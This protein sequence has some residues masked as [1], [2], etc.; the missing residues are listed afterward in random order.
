[1]IEG[2]GFSIYDGLERVSFKQGRAR[3][4]RLSEPYVPGRRSDR[5]W[6]EEWNDILRKYYPTGGIAACAAHLPAHKSSKASIYGHVNKLGLRKADGAPRRKLKVPPDIDD[7]LRREYE[8]QNGKKRGAVNA[9]A[10]K[11]GLPRWW[12][13]HRAIKLGLTMPHKKEP[14]W[15]AAETALMHKVPLHD[16]ARCSEIFRQH[17]FSRSPTAIVVRA[18]RL[19]ISR[20]FREGFSA[21]QAAEVV[22]FDGKVMATYCIEGACRA[23]R[24]ADNRLP[25]QGGARWV[26]TREDLRRFV[27]EHLDRIDLRKV[28]KLA[29]V[30]LIANQPLEPEAPVPVAIA[31]AAA[32]P[33]AED[34]HFSASALRDLAYV[35]KVCRKGSRR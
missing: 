2:Q 13:S 19:D 28:D 25:Q 20:R 12:V 18:K 33:K 23:T 5:F 1:M 21:G 15:T 30:Q 16:P 32:L 11:L 26:I 8:L 3:L 9:I 35:E 17:G 27:L 31:A 34:I 24:R 10:D 7:T 4:P 29:F 22:G 14:P 6:T